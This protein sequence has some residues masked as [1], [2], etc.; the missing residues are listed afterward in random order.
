M[1]GRLDRVQVDLEGN[2]IDL[3][4]AERQA[5]VAHL[6]EIVNTEGLARDFENAGTSMPVTVAGKD[7]DELLSVLS[8]WRQ[9]AGADTPSGIE[10]LWEAASRIVIKRTMPG[11]FQQ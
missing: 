4:W 8:Y 11:S 2:V 5:L 7:V 3:T 10:T 1:E 6:R 9:S